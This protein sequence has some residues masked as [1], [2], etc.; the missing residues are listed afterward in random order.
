MVYFTVKFNTM[1]A[2]DI[3]V[4][5]LFDLKFAHKNVNFWIFSESIINNNLKINQGE[6]CILGGHKSATLKDAKILV[7]S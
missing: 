7:S 4:W 2:I 5:L 6:K 1:T 3:D